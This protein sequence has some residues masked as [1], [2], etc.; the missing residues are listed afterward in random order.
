MVYMQWERVK[1]E[2]K[3]WLFKQE[4]SKNFGDFNAEMKESYGADK[5]QP[6][7]SRNLLFNV[8]NRLR[9]FTRGSQ[10]SVLIVFVCF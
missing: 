1:N 6:W 3:N 10:V 2:E 5:R 7:K 8:M 9:L 4:E